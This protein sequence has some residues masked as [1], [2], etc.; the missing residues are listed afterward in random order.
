MIRPS[1][2]DYFM[3]MAEIASRRSTCLSR[4]VGAVI[5]KDNA[6]I[7]TGYNGPAMGVKHCDELGGCRRRM[8]P[9]YKSG[10]YLEK[11][12]ASHAEQNAIALAARNGVATQGST[13]YVT[14]FPCK[15]CMNSII[16]AGIK[17][18]VTDDDYNAELSKEIANEADISVEKLVRVRKL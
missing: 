4:Q 8:M 16:N 7:S 13:I 2:D 6:V 9:D 10:S 11:C 18:V 3:D 12:P 5:A 14:T 17:R 15:D 1:W